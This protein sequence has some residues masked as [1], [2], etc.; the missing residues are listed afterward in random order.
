MG[1]ED[2]NG[3]I[4]DLGRMLYVDVFFILI[5]L[6]LGISIVIIF[7]E[8]VFGIVVGVRIGFVLIVIVVLFLVIF[9]FI[10]L[11]GIVFIYVVVFVFVMVGV[12]M[13]ESIK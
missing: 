5:G 12:F 7:G 1:F 3:E 6:F 13:F 4:K 8:F 11:F 10:L 9:I 2:E